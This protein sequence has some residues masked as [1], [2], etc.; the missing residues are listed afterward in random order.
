VTFEPNE[1]VQH[2]AFLGG[3]GS[4]PIGGPGNTLQ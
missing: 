1:F 2:A 4:E 3:S